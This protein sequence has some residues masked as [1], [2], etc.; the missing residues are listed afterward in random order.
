MINSQDRARHQRIRLNLLQWSVQNPRTLPWKKTRD[1]YVIWVSEIIL[2]QTRIEQGIPYFHR[3]IDRYPTIFDLALSNDNELMKIWEG[4]GYYRRAR[5]M[6]ETARKI[7]SECNGEFPK[8]YEE[9]LSLKGIGTYT[10]AAIASFAYDLPYVVIDGNVVR[11]IARLEGITET[12]DK[13]M[14]QDRIEWVANEILAKEEAALFNQAIMDFGAMH[15][16][17]ANPHCETCVLAI[18]C[19]ANQ[20]GTTSVIPA[21]RERR[22]KRIRYFYYLVCQQEDQIY[23]KKRTQADI[24]QNLFEFYLIESDESKDWSQ[25]LPDIELGIETSSNAG[26]TYKQVLSHQIIFTSFLEAKLNG[27]DS[28]L[29]KRDFEAV[30]TENIKNFAFP[31]VIDCYLK[32]KGV[33]LK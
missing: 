3:F 19:K 21:K 7:V 18:D 4:L 29:K 31:R 8:S 22:P 17:P 24:W 23:I 30:R 10:A 5:Y 6:L 9:I 14:V 16:K 25:I 12:V 28:A 1:P 13:R 26:E 32:D 20:Q 33:I 15:C 2:Q 27:E 11:V